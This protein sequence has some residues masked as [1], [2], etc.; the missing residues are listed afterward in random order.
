MGRMNEI[1]AQIALQRKSIYIRFEISLDKDFQTT[2]EE[3]NL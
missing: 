1:Q 2:W 3:Q